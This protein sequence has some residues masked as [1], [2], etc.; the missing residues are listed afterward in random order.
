MPKQALS[1]M[2]WKE[3]MKQYAVGSF[4]FARGQKPQ[5]GSFWA[6]ELMRIEAC[7]LHKST[8]KVDVMGRELH[9]YCGY[10]SNK[11]LQYLVTR[12][13]LLLCH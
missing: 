8:S 7:P 4:Q 6:K 13:L 10:H 5:K 3:R 11:V 1:K 9:C 12:L 2:E